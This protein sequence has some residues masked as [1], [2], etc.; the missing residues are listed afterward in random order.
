M[1]KN[2]GK[3]RLQTHELQFGAMLST[4]QLQS[5]IPSQHPDSG[6]RRI[7]LSKPTIFGILGMVSYIT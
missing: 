6:A 2:G 5:A 7:V 1:V 3:A 4:A